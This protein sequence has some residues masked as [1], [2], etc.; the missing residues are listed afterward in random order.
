[1]TVGMSA[2]PIG[3]I[4]ITPNINASPMM[5]R[6]TVADQDA[7]GLRTRAAPRVTARRSSPMLTAF[8]SGKVTGRCGI[9]LISCSLPAAIRLPVKVRKPRMISAT[10]AVIRNGVRL[11]CASPSQRK[12]SAVP[13]RPAARPPKEWDR[14]VRCGTAVRGTRDSGQPTRKPAA[15]A[16][17]IQT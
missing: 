3:M 14:A 4:S 2:P 7:T 17:A 15:I 11:A 9:H 13:T 10:M 16:R 6:K 12:Y 1:M 5:V 8:C